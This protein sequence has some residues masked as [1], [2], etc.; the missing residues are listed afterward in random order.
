MSRLVKLA[1]AGIGFVQEARAARKS[2]APSRTPSGD[3]S[4]S[5][6][7]VEETLGYERHSDRGEASHDAHQDI[8]DDEELWELDEAAEQADPPSHDEAA[9]PPAPS[10]EEMV[11]SVVQNLP[12]PP[13]T[14]ARLPFPVIIPQRRPRE[15][16][17]GFVRAYAP[18]LED[19]GID[20]A[21]FLD[22]LKTFHKSSQASPIF[23]V[24][25]LGTFAA[26]LVPGVVAM[27]T[28]AAINAVVIPSMIAQTRY[29][30]NSFL[31]D[32]NEQL[33]KP[34]GLY[35][36][37]ISFKPEA[38]KKVS[39]QP[40]DINATIVKYAQPSGSKFKDGLR[41]LRMS[42]GKTCGE[43]ELPE[44]APLVFPALDAALDEEEAG[45]KQSRFKKGSKF[46]ADY[47]DRRAQA[48]FLAESPNSALVAET[49]QFAS[50]FSDP[51]HPANN[52]HL[53]SLV[54]GGKVNRGDMR[55][56]RRGL[57]GGLRGRGIGG[58]R[59]A[60]GS[61][62]GRPALIGKVRKAIRQDVLYLMIVNLPT[63]EEL[64]LATA[65]MQQAEQ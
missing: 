27:A 26:G 50:R 5:A 48:R 14:R 49:P 58:H 34:R 12:P 55:R 45:K 42:S 25:L 36:M 10:R 35:A 15:K 7:V 18:V 39:A 46:I 51:N 3:A 19:C 44:A 21:T 65:E 57:G 47:Q 53:I 41:T 33:F 52:G 37:L 40:M 31:D 16:S 60:P 13:S 24:I 32:M 28:T 64:A 2:P 62:R 20:A 54:T 1:G 17:R 22:F 30:T 43:M 59:G 8:D 61:S 23:Q 63:D 38:N 9:S 4:S 29:R 56:G 11:R 6:R